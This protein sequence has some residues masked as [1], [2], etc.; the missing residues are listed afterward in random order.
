M[1]GIFLTTRKGNIRGGHSLNCE[2]YEAFSEVE[3][4]WRHFLNGY[5]KNII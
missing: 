2:D 3:R 1:M 4:V 5:Y